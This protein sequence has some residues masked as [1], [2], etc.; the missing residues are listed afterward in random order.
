[1][2]FSQDILKTITLTEKGTRLTEQAN[3]YLFTV[4]RSAN[5]IEIKRAVEELFNVT[6][7]QVNTLNRKGKAKRDRRGR[8]GKTSAT[9][10]AIVTVK[11]GQTIETT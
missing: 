9:K 5:K 8:F 10:R 2:K 4:D 6:V 1:M 3:Q 7:E 11:D